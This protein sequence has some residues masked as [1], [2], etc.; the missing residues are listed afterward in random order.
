MGI[1]NEG[2]VAPRLKEFTFT[3]AAGASLSDEQDLAGYVPA[4]LVMSATWDTAN[5]TLTATR[6][7]SHLDVYDEAGSEVTFVV[8]A[9]RYVTLNPTPL[10]GLQ[11]VKLRSGTTGT[12]VA[13]SAATTVTLLARKVD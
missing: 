8:A 13:Q 2:H 7:S 9:S 4:A 3:W 10:R 11:K 6:N 12:P 5:I 1:F